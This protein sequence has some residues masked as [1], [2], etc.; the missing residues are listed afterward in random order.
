MVFFFFSATCL[1]VHLR[2]W[3]CVFIQTSR[4]VS[5]RT[6]TVWIRTVCFECPWAVRCNRTQCCWRLIGNL[7]HPT[8]HWFRFR[9][10]TFLFSKFFFLHLPLRHG[11]GV[12][13]WTE[14]AAW[15]H[16]KLMMLN[17]RRRWFHSSRMKL[18]FVNVSASWFLVSTYLIW[19]LGS[20]ILSNEQSSAT[21]YV[22]TF[23]CDNH[24]DY[25]FI[26]FK[27]V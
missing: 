6:G 9:N 25:C 17:K 8:H 22:R 11:F 24:L 14:V 4:N 12:V 13:N 5:P 18:P 20:M 15:E 27:N 19:I 16:P 1:H 2:T 26:V 3:C 7:R 21:L 23:A 10:N